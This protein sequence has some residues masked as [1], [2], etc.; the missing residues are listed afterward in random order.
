MS[1]P[2]TL[3]LTRPRRQAGEWLARLS[4]LGVAAQ[5]LPLIEIVPG[6][7]QAADGAWAQLPGAALAMFVSPNA[8]E[9]FFAAR[10]GAWPA[11]TLAACVGPGSARALLDAGV[12]ADLIVQ[13]P[14]DAQSL[15]SEHLWPLLAGRDWSGKLALILRGDGGR[16][17]LAERLRERGARTLDFSVYQRRCPVLDDDGQ[18]LLAAILSAPERNVWLFSSAEAIGHLQS[19]APAGTGW[20]SGRCIATH[21][22]IAERARAVGVGNVVLARPDAAAVVQALRAMQDGNLQSFSL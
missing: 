16:D 6:A 8:V 18:A 19:L 15:D 7:Q 17:W 5:S 3:V 10:S 2:L 11:Q 14:A 9:H 12:P 20:A 13:P 21:A 22:R 1:A 4:A